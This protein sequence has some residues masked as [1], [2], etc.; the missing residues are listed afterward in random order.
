[1]FVSF[2]EIMCWVLE[3]RTIVTIEASMAAI[4]TTIAVATTVAMD[5]SRTEEEA[6]GCTDGGEEEGSR[7]N[8]S[9]V[10]WRE[11]KKRILMC[12][13]LWYQVENDRRLN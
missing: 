5:E 2:K 4:V 3:R 12:L 9:G 10:H 13:E 11:E 7:S 1:M 6:E 8:K